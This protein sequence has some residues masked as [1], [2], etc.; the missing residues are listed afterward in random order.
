MAGKGVYK[1][2]AIDRICNSVMTFGGNILLA[3]MLDP[4]DF[5]L[6]AMVAIFTAL[7]Y[8]I[9]GCGMSDGLINKANPTARDYS[10]VFV[11][12]I[13]MGV[14]F[15]ILFVSC[16][17]LVAEY[18]G[19]HQLK[20]IMIA[21]GICFLFQSMCLIQ[22]TRMRKELDFKKMAIVRLSATA[23]SLI[24]A[25]ILVLNGYSYWGLVS[26]Q[27]FLSVF[28]FIY[29]VAV[30]R[31]IPRIAFYKDS[32][33]EM[34]GYGVHLMLAYVC[35]QFARNINMSVLGKYWQAS[36]AGAY[37]QGQKLQEVPFAL[38]E[39]ILNW[40]FF[41]VL[42]STEGASER[43]RITSDM[44][45]TIIFVNATL[46]VFLFVI[47]SY[48]FRAL[49]GAKWDAAIP[50][51]NILLVFGL[52]TAVKMFYQ[53]IFKAHAMTRLIRNLTF[54]E[55]IIQVALL[56]V[57]YD[58]SI[59]MIAFTTVIPAVLILIVYIYYYIKI[60]NISVVEYVKEAAWP[61]LL[62]M[63]IMGL[64]YLAT[65]FWA[66]GLNRFVALPVVAL[67]F[68]SIFLAVCELIKPKAYIEFKS[69]LLQRRQQN[70]SVS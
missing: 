33:K 43:R 4:F 2:T 40:P 47:S 60:E 49:Y 48:A 32:F 64:S 30:S 26:M 34:F 23:S 9:S 39:S 11:F 10:T 57:F 37:N 6:L 46:T 69:R 17:S 41:A 24:L 70:S 52:A 54:V 1:W 20:G 63:L 53:T 45:S 66:G 18:F 58:Y 51:F 8:N 55:I 31:W 62:P 42:A 29:Y 19:Y 38:T 68:A 28:L 7:A 65:F 22:E 25:I 35:Y 67:I 27:V 5:G 21:I 14:L 12:N 13:C 59:M 36:A 16:S 50:I 61:L 3:N 15:C 56:A 44:H